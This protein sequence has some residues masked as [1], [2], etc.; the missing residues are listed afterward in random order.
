MKTPREIYAAY[1]IM[2]AL[3]THQLRVAAVGK[4]ICDNFTQP[5]EKLDVILACLFHDMGN[6]VKFKLGQIPEFLE[7]EGLEYWQRVKDEFKNKYGNDQHEASKQI[8]REL[9][10]PN[11]V[12]GYIDAVAFAKAETTLAS[13]SWEEKICEYADTRVSPHGIL[14]LVARLEEGRKR[15]EGRTA[16]TGLTA[17]RGRFDE[18]LDAERAIEKQIFAQAT[19]RP[20]D[21][22][23]ATVAPLVEELWEYPVS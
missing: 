13:G 7:P 22:N 10:L 11:P 20:E 4:L 3:Q 2:P 12:I 9:G 18:L 17:S 21:I 14:P 6:I 1:K 19:I 23:D 16:D 15:Y 8:A 5:I